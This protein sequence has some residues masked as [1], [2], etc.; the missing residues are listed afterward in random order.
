MHSL[1]CLLLRLSRQL[2]RRVQQPSRQLRRRVQQ[3]SRYRVPP[4]RLL[5]QP[6]RTLLFQSNKREASRVREP[7]LKGGF[8]CVRYGKRLWKSLWKNRLS[9]CPINQFGVKS[10]LPRNLCRSN[11]LKRNELLTFFSRFPK[12]KKIWRGLIESR[13]FAHLLPSRNGEPSATEVGA[14]CSYRAAPGLEAHKPS[15]R[16]HAVQP[17]TPPGECQR[18]RFASSASS[19]PSVFPAACVC[20]RCRRRNTWR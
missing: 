15:S 5:S 19:L 8:S 17:E 6:L 18:A 9:P 3:P 12:G 16:R 1:V 7:L 13:S 20:A 2:R 4:G 11:S 10:Y 14:I